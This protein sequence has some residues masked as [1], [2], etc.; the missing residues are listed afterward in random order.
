MDHRDFLGYPLTSLW[1]D[2]TIGRFGWL[3]YSFPEW[4]Y[5]VA[6][7]V[8]IALGLLACSTLV[9]LRRLIVPLLPLLG[10]FAV[11]SVGLLGAIGYTGIRY[12]VNTGLPFEQARYL[13]PLL[14]LYGLFMVLA[15][16]GVGRRWAP[17]LGAALVVLAMAHGLFAET[18][19]I[20]RY[21]G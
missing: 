11:M 5:T 8:F 13:F 7:W 10:C 1:L 6:E 12:R 15:A 21:Y 4:V 3:D 17:A 19:T 9:R 20:S 14:A 18:L 16:R 2:G